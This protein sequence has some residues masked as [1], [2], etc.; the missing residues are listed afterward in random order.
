MLKKLLKTKKSCQKVAEQ[1]VERST[2]AHPGGH[3]HGDRKPTETLAVEFCYLGVNLS[4]E[5]L[6]N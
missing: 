1:L 2:G 3:Q 4:L 5:E 6:R